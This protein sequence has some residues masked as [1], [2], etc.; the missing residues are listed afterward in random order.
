ML[1]HYFIPFVPEEYSIV[2]MCHVFVKHSSVG[3]HLLLITEHLVWARHCVGLCGAAVD[4]WPRCSLL[5]PK[6]SSLQW[7]RDSQEGKVSVMGRGEVLSLV[8]TSQHGRPGGPGGV[9]MPGTWSD[10][11]LHVNSTLFY[12][13]KTSLP[14]EGGYLNVTE[15]KI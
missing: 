11:C 14:G 15:R 13:K 2:Y 9:W 8:T 3:G 5:M 6:G 1:L 7:D 12:T 4:G 10:V